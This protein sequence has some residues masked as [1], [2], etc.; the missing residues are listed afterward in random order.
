MVLAAH[1]DASY[2]SE[3]KAQ[4]RAGGQFFMSSDIAVPKNNGAVHTVAQ[5]VKT[6]MSFAAEAELEALYINCR[7]AIQAR[8]LLE[9]MGHK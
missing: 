1:I 2:F 7:E 5:I 4:S 3:T 9:A 8:H 6:V